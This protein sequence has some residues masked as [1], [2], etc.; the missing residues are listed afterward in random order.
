MIVLKLPYPPSINVYWLASGHR[1]YISKRGMLFKQA[2]A[3]YVQEYNTP[4]LGD[5]K[6]EVFI[7]IYPRSKKLMDI[8]NCAKPVLDACQDAGIF[9]ND[10]QVE[11]LHIYRGKPRKGGGVTVLIDELTR[12]ATETQLG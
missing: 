5:A 9:D 2:V 3:D 8:D 1:R 10:V 6:V 7:Y 12:V 11:A 4:K